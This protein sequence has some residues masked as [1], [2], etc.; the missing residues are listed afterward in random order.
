MGVFDGLDSP[1]DTGAADIEW[2]CEISD[3]LTAWEMDFA[4][5]VARQFEETGRLS[6]RQWE[7]VHKILEE[8]G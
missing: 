2:L 8:K 7:I 4:E 6:D 1:E 3:G 5:S